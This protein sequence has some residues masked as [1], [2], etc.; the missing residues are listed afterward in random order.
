MC[1]T[2]KK[3]TNNRL[4]NGY[5]TEHGKNVRGPK[6]HMVKIG[7]SGSSSVF[8]LLIY[9]VARRRFSPPTGS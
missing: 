1:G 6:R 7:V 3:K 2:T 9:G 8:R 4:V 5:G